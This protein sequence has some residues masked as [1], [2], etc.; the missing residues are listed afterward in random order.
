MGNTAQ[1]QQ[2]QQ[3]QNHHQTQAL[4]HIIP[5][6]VIWVQR[7]WLL[8]ALIIA[9]AYLLGSF[10]AQ[11]WVPDLYAPWTWGIY[12]TIGVVIFFAAGA[13]AGGIGLFCSAKAALAFQQ[14]KPAEFLICLC[15]TAV[16]VGAEIWASL[17]ERSAYLRPQPPDIAV[18][19]AFGVHHPSISITVLV[20]SSL[21]PAGTLFY[22][23]AGYTPPQKSAQEYEED[24]ARQVARIHAEA[25]KRQARA[26][27]NA[28]VR[29]TQLRGLRQTVATLRSDGVGDDAVGGEPPIGDA[30]EGDDSMPALA[31]VNGSYDPHTS[32]DPD[33]TG[34]GP[35]GA[36][37]PR[38]SANTTLTGARTQPPQQWYQRARNSGVITVNDLRDALGI[39]AT[40]ATAML[41]QS[42]LASRASDARNAPLQAPLAAFLAW[43]E[44]D[45][46]SAE[47][48]WHARTLRAGLA[49]KG[50]GRNAGGKRRGLL[51][52]SR[53]S[54]NED[55]AATHGTVVMLPTVE[56]GSDGRLDPRASEGE[57][58]NPVPA[59]VR[60]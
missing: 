33:D 36:R 23:F 18:L 8:S 7:N 49:Q 30:G 38:R 24:A 31:V 6:W 52:D 39:G 46:Q 15:G 21:L 40:R 12:G 4:E 55:G 22:G 59:S 41:K 25:L 60:A 19:S 34:G 57:T 13:M 17:I 11:G 50:A 20:V 37:R 35:G 16:F 48:R 42:A 45:A 10:M 2:N 5:A 56:R 3:Q 43:L 1:Q 14:R 32:D 51:A 44:Q 28:L 47:N 53:S 29:G 9:E 27:A 58:G 54:G 26:E